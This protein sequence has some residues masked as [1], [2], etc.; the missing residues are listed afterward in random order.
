MGKGMKYLC[1]FIEL[2]SHKTTIMRNVLKQIFKASVME[3]RNPGP[4]FHNIG[5][6]FFILLLYGKNICGPKHISGAPKRPNIMFRF[7][8]VNAN[9]KI[10]FVVCCLHGVKV[11]N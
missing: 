2:H 1:V 8:T 6:L 11:G 10:A 7:S 4:C 5:R 9:R 3:E